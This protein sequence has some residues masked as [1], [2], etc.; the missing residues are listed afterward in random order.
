LPKILVL[1]TLK[2]NASGVLMAFR[3]RHHQPLGHLSK[4]TDSVLTGTLY[5]S[6]APDAS[7]PA[8]VDR[9]PY[10]DDPIDRVIGIA[11]NDRAPLAHGTSAVRVKQPSGLT[12]LA[13]MR[14]F[15][16]GLQSSGPS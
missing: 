8:K 1:E 11:P 12:P 9:H 3:V 7:P 2:P 6:S 14:R 16:V 13:V 15:F 10:P 4:G 5:Y